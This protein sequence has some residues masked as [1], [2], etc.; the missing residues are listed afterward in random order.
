MIKQTGELV[1]RLRKRAGTERTLFPNDWRGNEGA[2]I[3][4]QAAARIEELQKLADEGSLHKAALVKFEHLAG[5]EA[6]GY[7]TQLKQQAAYIEAL[8]KAC[9]LAYEGL[10]TNDLD[11]CDRA[12]KFIDQIMPDK[13][14]A[15]GEETQNGQE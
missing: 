10:C 4:E 11:A 12:I 1:K 6:Q 9:G 14:A 7:Q 2:E 15:L 8:E 5:E 3:Y 13:K